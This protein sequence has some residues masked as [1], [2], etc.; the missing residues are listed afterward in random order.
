MGV[1]RCRRWR[2][3]NAASLDLGFANLKLGHRGAQFLLCVR[4]GARYLEWAFPGG[5]VSQQVSRQ[6][7]VAPDGASERELLCPFPESCGRCVA[8]VR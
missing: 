2:A 3:A 4:A 8:P 6:S 1:A 7:G 5:R